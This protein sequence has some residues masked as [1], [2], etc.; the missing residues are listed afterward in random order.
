MKDRNDLT[1]TGWGHPPMAGRFKTRFTEHD[2]Q[3]RAAYAPRKVPTMAVRH[4]WWKQARIG[5]AIFL[6]FA[7]T[8]WLV[9][10]GM[11]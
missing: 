1:V 4:L 7:L 9:V 6:C 3:L 11:L 8:V 2:I 10:W 5:L